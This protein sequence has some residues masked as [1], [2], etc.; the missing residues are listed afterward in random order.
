MQ[1]CE[2]KP[3]MNYIYSASLQGR[4]A[5]FYE[6]GIFIGI[7]MFNI[8][9]HWWSTARVLDEELVLCVDTAFHGFARVGID[10][11]N[12]QAKKYRVSAI[13][14][15]CIFQKEPQIVLNSYYKDGFTQTCPTCIKEVKLT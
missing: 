3:T 4:V 1:L 11:L 9:S 7:V 5:S 2:I 6:K 10:F 12:R 8:G 15:G 13:V 14:A